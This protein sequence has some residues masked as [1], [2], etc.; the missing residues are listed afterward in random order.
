[1]PK[2]GKCIILV[3]FVRDYEEDPWVFQDKLRG[4]RQM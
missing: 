3:P 4:I 2:V 1:M